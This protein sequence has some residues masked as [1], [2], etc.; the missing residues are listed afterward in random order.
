MRRVGDLLRAFLAGRLSSEAD[1]VIELVEAWRE[2]GGQA[3]QHVRVRDIRGGAVVLE[4]DHPGWGQLVSLR[5][6]ELLRRLRERFPEMELRELRIV[7]GGGGRGNVPGAGKGQG[8]PGRGGPADREE[9]DR[10]LSEVP[11]GELRRA[12][13]ALYEK[14]R[15]PGGSEPGE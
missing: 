9:M 3:A 10:V 1:R 14:A 7:A 4:A 8:K 11:D 2:L 5:R 13:R 12:L 6:T 15:E